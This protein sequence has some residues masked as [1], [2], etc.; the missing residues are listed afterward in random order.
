MHKTYVKGIPKGIS[1]KDLEKAHE[2]IMLLTLDNFNWLK[3]G[4]TVLIKGAVNSKDQYPATTSP[5]AVR[6]LG[7]LIKDHGGIAKFGD[8][9][10]VEY[11]V[12]TPKGVL[13]G[14]SHECFKE[15][16]LDKCG[17]E[18][19]AFEDDAWDDFTHFT[20]RQAAN[21]PNGLYITPWIAKADHIISLPR[22]ST[23]AQ[24]G[25]TLGAKNWV[26]I[27]R[28]DS[29]MLFHAQGPFNSFIDYYARGSKLNERKIPG[30]DFFEMIA[31]I[32]LAVSGK[33]RG[34]I[35][36]AT[37][38]QTAL[39]PNKYLFNEYGLKLFKAPQIKP[40]LGLIIGSTDPVAADAVALAFLFDGYGQTPWLKKSLQQ[41]LIAL[42]GSIHKLG[43]YS[44]WSNPFI[45]HGLNLGLGNKFDHINTLIL[46]DCGDLG[47]RIVDMTK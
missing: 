22:I 47:K 33:L 21:W 13:R 8:Q 35:F 18:C 9:S 16:G 4:E 32:Q 37:E 36:T 42:N 25:V 5:I 7:K 6:V 43:T 14:S 28:Q 30:L 46:D 41:L 38:L 31:E 39:G 2:Q 23:H 1:E 10:G 19:V 27:L 12:H 34:T 11:V 44:V 15:T 40:E 3:A 45:A 24:G 20:H 26:G 17:V 29:R